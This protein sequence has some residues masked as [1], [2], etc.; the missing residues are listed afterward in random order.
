MIRPLDTSEV[1]EIGLQP[2]E[3]T[4]S[5]PAP[6]FL[7]ASEGEDSVAFAVDQLIAAEAV[8]FIAGEPKSLKTWASLDCAFAI[9]TGA[10]AFGRFEPGIRGPVLLAQ[11]ESRSAD[12]ARRL[13]WLA[14]GHGLQPSDLDN[15]HIASQRGLRLD[16]PESQAQLV[17]EIRRLNPVMVLLD[18]LTRM[19]SADEDRASGMRPV[20]SFLRRLQAEHACA[21]L[22]IHHWTKPREG[23]KVRPGQRL[24][25]T[26]DLYAMLDSA[27]YLEARSGMRLVAVT[28]EHREAPAPEPFT[29]RLE[30]DEETGTARLIA[31]AGTLEDMAAVEAMPDVDAALTAHPEGLTGRQVEA[32]VPRRRQLVRE[33]IRKLEAAGRA[34][35]VLERREDAAGRTRETKVW[36]RC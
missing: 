31:E 30:E 27:L 25:G 19:H 11:E 33:A 6:A 5:I 21:V 22:V 32:I 23:T 4:L 14:R 24:R 26:G 36:K 9:A 20:L 28:V 12:Y 13:R 16:E 17:A 2:F 8:A 18:P 15:L 7:A 35:S 10:P 3:V 1:E 34:V 29:L